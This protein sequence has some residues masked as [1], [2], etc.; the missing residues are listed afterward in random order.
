MKGSEIIP[1]EEYGGTIN[2]Q[3]K[4]DIIESYQFAATVAI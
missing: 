3:N 4:L 1:K 2:G